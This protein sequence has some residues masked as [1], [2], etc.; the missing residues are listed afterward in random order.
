[1]S[2]SLQCAMRRELNADSCAARATFEQRCL[3]LKVAGGSYLVSSHRRRCVRCC[4]HFPTPNTH[5]STPVSRSQSVVEQRLS[6]VGRRRLLVASLLCSTLDSVREHV[7]RAWPTNRAHHSPYPTRTRCP[8]KFQ[9]SDALLIATHEL[10][11]C[12]SR[13][14]SRTDATKRLFRRSNHVLTLRLSLVIEML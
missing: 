4:V 3:R 8:L 14:G 2:G 13:C 9:V 6:S 1:M 12:E 5:C 7:Q 10:L 11:T